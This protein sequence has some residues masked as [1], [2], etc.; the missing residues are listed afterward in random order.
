MI[1]MYVKTSIEHVISDV[2]LL[3]TLYY[4]HIFLWVGFIIWGGKFVHKGNAILVSGKAFISQ[5]YYL[6]QSWMTFV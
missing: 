5:R 2:C 6:L 3:C 4:M 1:V